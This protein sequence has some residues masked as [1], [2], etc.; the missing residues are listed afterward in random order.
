MIDIILFFHGYSLLL[1]L[2]HNHE[3]EFDFSCN[4]LKR[5]REI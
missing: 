2:I 3:S 1:R 5:F 4:K